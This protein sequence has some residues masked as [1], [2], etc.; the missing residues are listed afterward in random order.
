MKKGIPLLVIYCLSAANIGNAGEEIVLIGSSGSLPWQEGGGTIAA[1]AILDESTVNQTN[2][3]G[4]VIDF[5]S[6]DFPGWIFPQRVDTTDNI[7]IGL[8]SKERGG[9]ISSPIPSAQVSFKN[10]YKKLI[11]ADGQTALE[12]RATSSASSAGR[13]V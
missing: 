6:I 4:G 3:P 12:V 13:S 10:D 11:D 7:L 2:T 5:D 8:T 9:S 1:T